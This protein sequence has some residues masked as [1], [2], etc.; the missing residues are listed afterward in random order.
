LNQAGHLFEWS[1]IKQDLK[2][3]KA[4]QQVT[5]EEDG[6]YFAIRSE[7]KGYC[8]K[9]FQAVKVAVPPTIRAVT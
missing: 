6:K 5:I 1:V 2:D 8:G 9:I 4:L 7:C 3:L